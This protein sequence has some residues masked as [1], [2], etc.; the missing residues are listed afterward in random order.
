LIA[1]LGAAFLCADLQ[2]SLEP[3]ADTA[4]YIASWLRVLKGDARAI[5]IAAAL[6]Q[7]AV[8]WLSGNNNGIP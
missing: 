1:E 5:F 8:D 7:N 4:A 3:R 2:I 6:A